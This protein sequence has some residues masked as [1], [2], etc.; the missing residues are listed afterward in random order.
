MLSLSIVFIVSTYFLCILSVLVA[1]GS[2]RY[3]IINGMDGNYD[4][5][6]DDDDIRPII[7]L[8]SENFLIAL[9]ARLKG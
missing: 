3:Y 8:Q 9:A 6:D 7:G 4:D 1:F 5:D 2:F